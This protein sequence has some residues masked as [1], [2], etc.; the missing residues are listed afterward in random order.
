MPALVRHL[1]AVAVLP[2][3]VTI[4]V[5]LWI[6]RRNDTAVGL[7]ANAV[8]IGAQM[9][10]IVAL[11]VGLVLFSASLRRFAVDGR[12]TLAPWDP[13]EKLVVSGPY[14]YVRNPMISGVLFILFAEALVLL[15]WPHA[16]WAAS[17]L[18]LNMVQFPLI[19]EPQLERRF[20]DSYREYCKHVRRFVPRLRPWPGDR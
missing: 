11:I 6:A 1:V 16:V 9:A 14:R 17:F 7:G 8:Q 20:G 12:G 18:V 5:P 15:S 13:P 19:E 4:L 10:G 3:T 2:V